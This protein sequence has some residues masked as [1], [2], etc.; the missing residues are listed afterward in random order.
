M[1]ISWKY[2]CKLKNKDCLIDTIY[3]SSV[4][5]SIPITYYFTVL[6][7]DG[8]EYD[9]TNPKLKNLLKNPID[10]TALLDA[11]NNWLCLSTKKSVFE[12]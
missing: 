4:Q 8:S 9:L 11:K 10:K 2:E 1:S 5:M 7:K 12:L 6:L 3:C